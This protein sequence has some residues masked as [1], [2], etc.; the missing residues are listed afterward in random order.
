MNNINFK[1]AAQEMLGI[2]FQGAA[3]VV[4][5]YLGYHI[6][7]LLAPTASIALPTTLV[8]CGIS[9]IIFGMTGSKLIR[10]NDSFGTVSYVGVL[11]YMKHTGRIAAC[12]PVVAAEISG[13]LAYKAIENTATKAVQLFKAAVVLFMFPRELESSA[14]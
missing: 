13:I 12:L 1:E 9:G 14:G 11:Y 5:G 7:V 4:K 3:G 8:A 6:V 10:M 2:A